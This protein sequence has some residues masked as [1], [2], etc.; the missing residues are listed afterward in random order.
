MS[1]SNAPLSITALNTVYVYKYF[2][3]IKKIQFR[4]LSSFS[5]IFDR[6]PLYSSF[7]PLQ[8]YRLGCD[9]RDGDPLP[10]VCCNAGMQGSPSASQLRTY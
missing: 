5:P 8:Y 10:K 2:V 7:P 6:D 9:A 1:Q 3:R 4:S